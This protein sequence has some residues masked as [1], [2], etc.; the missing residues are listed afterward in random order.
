MPAANGV[1]PLYL[2]PI[3]LCRFSA[4]KANIMPR[5]ILSKMLMLLVWWITVQ[6]IIVR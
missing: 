6:C 3:V 5:K 4:V 2:T 1:D